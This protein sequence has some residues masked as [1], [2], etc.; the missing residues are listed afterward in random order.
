MA[1]PANKLFLSEDYAVLAQEAPAVVASKNIR[2]LDL[3][4][5]IQT[6]WDWFKGY[7]SK[8]KTVELNEDGMIKEKH[9]HH[10]IA[11]GEACS[12]IHPELSVD[13]VVGNPGEDTELVFSASGIASVF[14]TV[15]LVVDH[16]PDY[17]GWS[18]IK[19]RPRQKKFSGLSLKGVRLEP[20]HM[21]FMVTHTPSRGE[22]GLIAFMQGYNEDQ[23]EIFHHLG[24]LFIDSTLGEIDAALKISSFEFRALPP[25][26]ATTADMVTIY[27]LPEMFD[28][29][30]AEI[31]R[32]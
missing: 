10:V 30:F 11:L 28:K 18:F 17:K 24:F 16:A 1:F 5:R 12:K 3:M 21:R 26:G 31:S 29:K 9:I 20:G 4:Q 14:K 25:G 13:L 23:C 27:E 32:H 8:L 2:S 22:I 6:F 7:K 15:H 19:F